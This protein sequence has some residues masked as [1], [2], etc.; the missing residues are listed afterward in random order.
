MTYSSEPT[1]PA[2]DLASTT[3]PS[4]DP[5]QLP[6]I[7][8]GAGPCGLVA[9][10]TFQQRNVPFVIVEK[11]S[12][13]TICSNAGSGFEL[14]PTAIE[15]LQEGLGIEVSNFLST[16][17]G[18]CFMTVEGKTFRTDIL[19]SHYKGGS[20]NRAEMQNFLLKHLFA[21]PEDEE[22][23][24]LCGSGIDSYREV[25]E[26]GK[27]KT[28][29]VKL[30]SGRELVG[31]ALLACD[32]IHSKCRSVMHP[33]ETDP[34]HY[35]N[36]IC[37]WGKTLASNGS[38]LEREFN[39]TQQHTLQQQPSSADP[40]EGHPV[41][42]H[43][44]SFVLAMATPK[45][46]AALFIVP[47]KSSQEDHGTMLNWGLT[48]ASKTPPAAR[49]DG[50]DSTRRGGGVLT[51]AQKTELLSFGKHL[52]GGDN[53]RRWSGWCGKRNSTGSL[54]EGIQDFPLLEELLKV[55]PAREITE[56][57]FYDR[58][59]LDLPFT[60]KGK[61]VALLGDAAHPQTP[62][63]GQGVNMAITDA[64]IYASVIADCL[65]KNNPSHGGDLP[66]AIGW[67]D[68]KS[69]RKSSKTNVRIARVVCDLSNSSNRLVCWLFGRF[70]KSISPEEFVHQINN[71][72][73]SNRKF[74]QYFQR[75]LQST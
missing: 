9:A 51:E 71:T 70:I 43:K 55:T 64:Y 20:V 17:E 15:I 36:S 10:A 28:V 56:A 61:L 63:I 14:A 44:T 24:L 27:I 48:I 22:G 39:K 47:S 68:V 13:S 23:V 59:N 72:D 4:K 38:N 6:V 26:G 8:A 62:Y 19:P 5:K 49:K 52:P 21:S 1:A 54:L 40:K 32:G 67:C 33:P 65:D 73:S 46:P 29:V 31:C 74:W 41:T 53:G 69:R 18:M 30:A 57:G 45:V 2:V 34:L 11:V 50:G 35:C 12:R 58:K 7:I 66:S 25:E 37:Y 16:Y 42:T 3:S 75:R 60:S